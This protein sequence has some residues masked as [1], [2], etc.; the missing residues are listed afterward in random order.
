MTIPTFPFSGIIESLQL[1]EILSHIHTHPSEEILIIF[2]I[3]NTLLSSQQQLGS[4]AWGEHFIADLERKG[5]SHENADKIQSILW[6]SLH[7]LLPI[8]LIDPNTLHVIEHLQEKSI[9]F[10]CLTARAPE[11]ADYTHIQLQKIGI[12]LPLTWSM[13]EFPTEPKTTFDKGILF[14]TLRHRKS[15]ILLHFLEQNGLYPKKVIFIDDREEHVR[16]VSSALENKGIPCIGI[17]FSGADRYNKSF[18][19]RISDIQWKAFP[20]HISDEEARQIL[21]LMADG[22]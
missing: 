12:Q 16:D 1:E 9:T 20:Q 11:E 3:D 8:Q 5:I 4:V 15:E 18:D 10:L 6:K 14:A 2:D 7:P 19:P 17:R 21:S 22:S 13:Q